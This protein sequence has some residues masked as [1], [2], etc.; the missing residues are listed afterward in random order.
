MYKR[1]ILS[2]F[3]LFAAA[4]VQLFAQ[5]RIDRIVKDLESDA[6]VQVTYTEHRNPKNKSIVKQSTILNGNSKSQA[7]RLWAAFEKERE[8]SVSVTKT[9]N[10]SFVI[11]FVSK[12]YRSSY[13][14]SVSGSSW[15]LVISKNPVDGDETSSVDFDFDFSGLNALSSLDELNCLGELNQLNG[16][17]DRIAGCINGNVTVYDNN[18]NVIFKSDGTK[19]NE[20]AKA[21]KSKSK[22]T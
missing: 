4:S 6:N 1:L 13:V 5:D 19:S 21:K 7:E 15:S 11:K 14:L 3:L 17:G 8:N 16:L 10:Q 20:K 18:G 9:R 12:K 2:V 22:S